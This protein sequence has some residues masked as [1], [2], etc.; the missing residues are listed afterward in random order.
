MESCSP[1]MRPSCYIWF[2]ISLSVRAF[3]N[4]HD[5]DLFLRGTR[6]PRVTYYGIITFCLKSDPHVETPSF[7]WCCREERST[8]EK[9][10]GHITEFE[11]NFSPESH[12]QGPHSCESFLL[13][14]DPHV[15][16]TTFQWC[17]REERSTPEKCSG[18]IAEF[19]MN[20]APESHIQDPRSCVSLYRE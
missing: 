16:T 13:K 7:Q 8:L 5:I 15:E 18:H 10:A 2:R 19:E 3:H 12:I 20:F 14:V 9:C 6:R 1:R 11:M 17:C 4:H